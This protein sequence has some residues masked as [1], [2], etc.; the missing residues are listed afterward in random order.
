M[1]KPAWVREVVPG[2]QE[3]EPP[4]AVVRVTLQQLQAHTRK[5][6]ASCADITLQAKIFF[7]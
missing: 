3:R 6:V 7:L 4:A 5:E 2:V 1:W